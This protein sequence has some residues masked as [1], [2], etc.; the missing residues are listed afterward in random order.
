MEVVQAVMGYVPALSG[1]IMIG[2]CKSY[3]FISALVVTNV[4]IPRILFAC[5]VWHFTP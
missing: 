2:G 1:Q 4:Q 5:F 3:C